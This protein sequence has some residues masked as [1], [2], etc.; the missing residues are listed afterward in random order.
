MIARIEVEGLDKCGK[1]TLVGY[2]DYMSG[3]TIP[4]CSRGL[5][6]TIAYANI[7]DRYIDGKRI[8]DM[9]EANKETLIIYLTADLE[10]LK[11]RF[12]MSNEPE[13]DTLEH[14]KG[15]VYAKRMLSCHLY[16]LEFNTSK[17][18]PF[19]I[20]KSVIKFLEEENSK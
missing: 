1:D 7:F 2:L 15:F 8:N 16:F 9:I 12:K 18:T 4:I 3:R 13:I 10:D 19:E 11:I 6:S 20:A 14:E 17:W 5:M